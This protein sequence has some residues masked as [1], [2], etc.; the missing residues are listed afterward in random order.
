[1]KESL[2]STLFSKLLLFFFSFILVIEVTDQFWHLRRYKHNPEISFIFSNLIESYKK[3]LL[4]PQKLKA[5]FSLFYQMNLFSNSWNILL[6]LR[7]RLL[8]LFLRCRDRHKLDISFLL[9]VAE[10]KKRQIAM[11]S[12]SFFF[13]FCYCHFISLSIA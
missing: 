1:M 7:A 12:F 13:L 11:F 6:R 4:Y 8:D 3:G 9:R 10:K 2:S 5:F